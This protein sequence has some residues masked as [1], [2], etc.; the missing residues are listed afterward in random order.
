MLEAHIFKYYQVSTLFIFVPVINGPYLVTTFLQQNDK[1]LPLKALLV[2][3][4]YYLLKRSLCGVSGD[5]AFS[6]FTVAYLIWLFRVT[7]KRYFTQGLIN[8]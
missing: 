8:K 1:W 6:F 7:Y 3:A 5:Q 2:S 4:I